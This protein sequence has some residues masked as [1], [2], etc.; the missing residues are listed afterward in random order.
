MSAHQSLLGLAAPAAK[1][2]VVPQTRIGYRVHRD[3]PWLLVPEGIASQVALDPVLAPLPNVQSWFPGVLNLRGNLVPVF[4]VAAACGM[5]QADPKQC[6]ILVLQPNHQP[7][8]VL[9]MGM[10]QVGMG[11]PAA[12]SALP[13]NL[14]LLGPFLSAPVELPFGIGHEFRFREWIAWASRARAAEKPQD[15]EE[16]Q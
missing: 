16:N 2:A 8:G 3:M 7:L 4:D 12:N 6:T 9:C 14:R 15:H 13:E 1:V 10:P 11:I 5:P